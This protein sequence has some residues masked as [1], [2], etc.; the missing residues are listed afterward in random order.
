MRLIFK[1]LIT[2]LFCLS[3]VFALFSCKNGNDNEHY[4]LFVEGKCECGEKDPTYVPS[5][6]HEAC[7]E[8]GKCLVEDCKGD[9]CIGHEEIIEPLGIMIKIDGQTIGSF[10]KNKDLVISYKFNNTGIEYNAQEKENQ[11]SSEFWINSNNFT[12][13]L[14]IYEK[15]E[16]Y[17]INNKNEYVAPWVVDG[18]TEEQVTLEQ[19]VTYGRYLEEHKFIILPIIETY[20][21]LEVTIVGLNIDKEWADKAQGMTVQDYIEYKTHLEYDEYSYDIDN[22]KGLTFFDFVNEFGF[23]GTYEDLVNIIKNNKG[24]SIKIAI[25]NFIN[26]TKDKNNFHREFDDYVFACLMILDTQLY[27]DICLFDYEKYNETVE[28]FNYYSALIEKANIH[29]ATLLTWETYYRDTLL[30]FEGLE[31]E[32]S[33]GPLFTI[34]TDDNCILEFWFNTY[35]TAF[36]IIKKDQNGN[37]LNKFQS[38]LNELEIENIDMSSSEKEDLKTVFNLFFIYP[39]LLGDSIGEISNYKYS[40]LESFDE[41]NY[42]PKFSINID[43]DNKK[44]TVLYKLSNRGIDRSYFPQYIS[45]TKLDEYLERNKSLVEQGATSQNGKPITYIED[46]FDSN[47]IN[48]FTKFKHYYNFIPA[49]NTIGYN[50]VVNPDN[51]FGYDYYEFFPGRCNTTDDINF[52]YYWLYEAFLYSEDDL[53][54]DNNEFGYVPKKPK[55]DFHFEIAIEY[56]LTQ[57]GFEITIPGNSIKEEN[58]EINQII[59]FPNYIID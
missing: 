26:S 2:I 18:L 38:N 24:N 47:G 48:A 34:N 27:K 32:G 43:Y 21:D 45:A 20:N 39:G 44:V 25:K 14:D 53:K 4:H 12:N 52:L 58:G 23:T 7:P 50:K 22:Y 33:K 54:A 29:S 42:E 35:S 1:R 40:V 17:D 37:I 30:G 3:Y 56:K 10:D 5:H 9:K 57:N 8:C 16:K 51:K 11:Y 28:N 13:I 36:K 46:K 19:R 55:L 31:T 49:Y 41:Y 6:V 59:L 15:I